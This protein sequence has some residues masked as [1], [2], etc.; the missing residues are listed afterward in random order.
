MGF[1]L[2]LSALH[3]IA[4]I[5]IGI[6]VWGGFI[7]MPIRAEN[8][9]AGAGAEMSLNALLNLSASA[10]SAATIL[11][12]RANMLSD[13][14][15][16]LGSHKGAAERS[17]Q[18]IAALAARSNQLDKLYRFSALITQQGVLPPVITEARDAMHV[19]D[20]QM[21]I[22]DRLYK[23]VMPARFVTTPPSW[24]DYLFVGLT[25][26]QA[27][28]QQNTQP[29]TQ[30]ISAALPKTPTERA[31]WKQQIRYGYQHG[32][33]LADEI[34]NSNRARLERDYLG[35][36]RYAE[37]LHKGMVSEP[38][39]SVAQAIV[40]GNKEYINVGD[41]LYRMTHPGGFITDAKQWQPIVIPA[42]S[43]SAE[44]QR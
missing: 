23:I 25:V 34:F 41:T 20:Q 30:P 3:V 5:C 6:T 4:I 35:M 17:A 18:L 21:R 9:P 27:D 8:L 42:L 10:T 1:R 28:V 32:R 36:L 38:T 26:K 11:P 7:V 43:P 29:M 14:A 13:A 12:T 19:A 16:L 39:V 15:L 44:F 33:R 37:L 40:T 22:A 2:R 31:Y 24:R